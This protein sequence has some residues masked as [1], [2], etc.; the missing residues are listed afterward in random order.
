[1]GDN[2]ELESSSTWTRE[3]RLDYIASAVREAGFVQVDDLA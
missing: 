2:P 3:A 1:M